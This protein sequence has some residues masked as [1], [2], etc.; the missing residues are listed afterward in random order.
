MGTGD[1]NRHSRPTIRFN[2]NDL[3]RLTK[4][5]VV[6]VPMD[7]VEDAVNEWE[8]D[9][10]PAIIP[11]GSQPNAEPTTS[12]TATLPDPLTT[13]VLAEV[14]RRSRTVEVAPE[15]IEDAIKSLEPDDTALEEVRP[16]APRKR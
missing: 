11:A 2:T 5:E 3:A 7:E 12:R 4:Q 1:N 10:I 15:S 16:P 14:A 9:A 13:G 8:E 6:S